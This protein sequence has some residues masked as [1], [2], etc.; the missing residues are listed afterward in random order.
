M[1]NKTVIT[2]KTLFVLGAGVDVAL[3][4]PTMNNLLN[5]LARFSEEEGTGI[6]KAIR[7]HIKGIRFNLYKHAGEQGEHF[8]ELLISSH[9]HLIEKIKS[10]FNKY[11][12]Q[13]SSKLKAIRKVVENLEYIY[14]YNHLDDDICKVLGEISGYA[15]AESGGDFLFNPRG[16]TLTNPPRQA[17]RKML[18]GALTEIADLTDEEREALKEI[19]SMISNFEEMLGGFFSG[20]FTKNLTDQKKYFYLSWLLWAYLRVKQLENFHKRESS[21][22]KTLADL[23][24]HN[25]ISFNYTQ[26]F[27]T[28]DYS[29]IAYFHGDCGGY[30]RF[31]NRE[32]IDRDDRIEQAQ[33]TDDIAKFIAE[34]EVNWATEPP[35]LLLPSIVPPL[36]VKPIICNEYLDCWYSA[37]QRIKEADHILIIGYSFNVADEHFNDLIRKMGQQAKISLIN[38]DIAAVK[39]LV[40]RVLGFDPSQLTNTSVHGINRWKYGRLSLF[41][42]KAET[43]TAQKLNEILS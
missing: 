37:S 34:I 40:C 21:F 6:N 29:Q 7:N 2:D 25:V 42:A 19:V 5:E 33:T 20:F 3:G 11:D 30:I 28:D 1:A 41:E 10:V 31:D 23:G 32:Y 35:K 15:E 16:M 4:F 38:P 17:I 18:Q 8:G 14:R 12:N 22:Y 13:D 36:S 27:I 39:P 26:F 9:N 24:N 43:I